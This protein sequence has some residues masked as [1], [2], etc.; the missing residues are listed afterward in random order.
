MNKKKYKTFHMIT[1]LNKYR[2]IAAGVIVVVPL[3]A[4][5]FPARLLKA[6]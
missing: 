3:I 6:T 2:Y 1:G 4:G 5:P